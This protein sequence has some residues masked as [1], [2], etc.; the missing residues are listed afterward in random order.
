MISQKQAE[1]IEKEAIA[2]S[3]QYEDMNNRLFGME[4]TGHR[5]LQFFPT[6]CTN[7]LVYLEW[8]AN[9]PSFKVESTSHNGA[10]RKRF[11]HLYDA[12]VYAESVE[13]R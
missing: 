3:L 6:Y 13:R 8:Q 9:F 7:I 10:V 12:L 4:N 1:A 11:N 2:V 5:G